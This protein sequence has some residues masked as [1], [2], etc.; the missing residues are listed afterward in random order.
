MGHAMKIYGVSYK[1]V[2][3][4]CRENFHITGVTPQIEVT[5]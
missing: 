3:E 2:H 1:L 4:Q 5:K